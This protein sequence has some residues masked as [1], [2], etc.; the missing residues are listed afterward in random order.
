MSDPL[1]IE[2]E[3]RA[4][5]C[6]ILL[7]GLGAA[8]TDLYPLAPQL[9]PRPGV[10]WIFPAA[11]IRPIT[12]NGGMPMPGWYDVT[13]PSLTLRDSEDEEGIRS[14]GEAIDAIIERS[15]SSGIP[16]GNIVL[17]GF[18]QGAVISLQVGLRRA[19][20]LGALVAMSG[21]LPLADTVAK[22]R[23]RESLATPIFLA[24]G[25]RD[26]VIPVGETMASGQR[27]C[28]LGYDVTAR[29]YAME[30]SIVPQEIDHVAAFLGQ[31]TGQRQD[32]PSK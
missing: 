2:P 29:V 6:C 21:Y 30:H 25:E 10:R 27:L 20:P 31:L 19:E 26:P 18:S 3:G 13:A 14:S 32:P 8:S 16:P 23:T 5:H 11:P 24:A 17:G 1:T 28:E 7:H 15:V 9:W 4:T 12:V 22:E